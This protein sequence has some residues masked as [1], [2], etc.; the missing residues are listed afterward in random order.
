MNLFNKR[1][2][3]PLFVV[4]ASCALSHHSEAQL[5]THNLTEF[6]TVDSNGL[7]P[8]TNGNNPISFGSSAPFATT[9]YVRSATSGA[10]QRVKLYLQFDLSTLT[11]D[12]ITSATLDF[13]A[14]SLNDRVAAVNNPDLFVSQLQDDWAP[15]GTPDPIFQ[16]VLL[17]SVNG[18]GV[19]SG[20]GEDL[21]P[22][23]ANRNTTDYSIDVT[24]IVQNIQDGDVNNGFILELNDA[25]GGLSSSH[26]QGIGLNTSSLV[27]RVI[28]G[29]NPTTTLS[30]ASS[31]VGAD[32]TV[33]VDFSEDVTGLEVSDFSVTN[34][35]VLSVAGS[36]ANY[37]VEVSPIAEGVVEL[38]LP[39]DSVNATVGGL[40]NI[41]SNILVTTFVLPAPPTVTLSATPGINDIFTVNV[42][43]NEA[44]T[45]LELS[46][47]NITNGMASDLDGT[48]DSFTL[49]VVASALGS[50]EVT[51]PA[52]VVTDINDDLVNLVSNTLTVV[53]DPANSALTNFLNADLNSPVS[54]V[55]GTTS[56]AL[57]WS[58]DPA[59]NL[60]LFNGQPTSVR[61]NQWA[62]PALSGGFIFNPDGG[63]NGVG[64]GAFVQTNAAPSQNPRAVLYFVDDNQLTTGFVNFG[65][66][67]FLDD[68]SEA[69]PLQ[70]LVEV[71]GWNDG[72]VAPSLSAGGPTANDPNYNLTDLGDAVTVLQTQVL[73]TSVDEATWQTSALGLVDVGD[74]YDN[75]AWRVGALGATNGDSF[76]FDNVTAT[77]GVAPPMITAF[78][79]A[80][81]G[82]VTID[83]TS[84]GNVDVYR[85][86]DLLDFGVSPIDAN[87]A[88]GSYLD[89]T[90]V[91]LLRAFYILVPEGSPAP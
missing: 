25:A 3:V 6:Q 4:L 87:V 23:T 60:V 89:D 30:S 58:F 5:V 19:T 61:A 29:D 49:E 46:D 2:T 7:F 65:L 74:G 84:G 12:E 90:A 67:V 71:Y 22:G 13:S 50:V 37:T 15:D 86:T 42:E 51:L 62:L 40:G 24:S 38:S 91:G 81:N 56:G 9:T 73:A 54:T 18:G 43:F 32:Y 47:F 85:S 77:S 48:A 35:D 64:D 68:N 82:D 28:S 34:G 83:F 31:T 63:A 39:S 26:A 53:F 17:E 16:P 66:D 70:L 36:G 78:D 79:R 27:L 75:Y 57:A 33:N 10:A 41:E 1:R 45:G 52:G 59:A 76:A 69:N 44:V 11:T 80:A 55:P 20:T 8:A 14:Y 72:E 88:P 21:F